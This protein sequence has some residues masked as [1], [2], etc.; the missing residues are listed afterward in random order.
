MKLTH[1]GGNL[2]NKKRTSP[3]GNVLFITESIY[4][5]PLQISRAV[6]S[7]FYC[8]KPDVKN[9]IKDIE[10]YYQN[11]IDFAS[12]FLPLKI[13]S[14]TRKKCLAKKHKIAYTHI[15]LHK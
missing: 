11:L 8:S 15:R 9:K 6:S 14:V 13:D 3:Y 1:S 10:V 5:Y 12:Y 4:K 7:I 2:G